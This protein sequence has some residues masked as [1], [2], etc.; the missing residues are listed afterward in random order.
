MIHVLVMGEATARARLVAELAGDDRL[1][2]V[3]TA[4]PDAP[5]EVGSGPDVVVAAV[6]P[7]DE[8]ATGIVV[9]LAGQTGGPAVVAVVDRERR[10]WT[11]DALRAGVRAVIRRDAPPDELRAAVAAAAA[12]LVVVP[13]EADRPDAGEDL[14]SAL[15]PRELQVLNLLAFGLGNKAIGARLAISERTVKYHIGAIFEKLDVASRTEAVT[16]ALRRG[17]ILL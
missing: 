17:L 9:G 11:A 14:G 15:T 13:W 8:R 7:A 3:A 2:V 6:D 1:E 5:L 16:A 12:G 4:R 10:A